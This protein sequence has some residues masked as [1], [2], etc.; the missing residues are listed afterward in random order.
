VSSELPLLF[1]FCVVC[2]LD[3]G[4][5]KTVQQLIAEAKSGAHCLTADAAKAEIQ[6]KSDPLLID[7]REPAELAELAVAG[8]INIPRG[9]LEMKIGDIAGRLDRPIYI[10]CAT[11]GRAALSAAQLTLL[12]YSDVNVIDCNCDTLVALFSSDRA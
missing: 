11:G 10:H 7:V 1:I 6:S 9:V 5:M 4:I 8:F 12:G 3:G 2:F